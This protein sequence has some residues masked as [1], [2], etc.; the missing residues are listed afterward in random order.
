MCVC[1]F[2]CV[3]TRILFAV[4][5]R[6]LQTHR[7]CARGACIRSQYKSGPAVFPLLVPIS[8]DDAAAKQHR[9]AMN[10]FGTRPDIAVFMAIGM[11]DRGRVGPTGSL[12]TVVVHF[13]QWWFTLHSG[14]SLCT[15]VFHFAQWWFTLH[16]GGSLCTVVVHFAQCTQTIVAGWPCECVYS[17]I[18]CL[19]V[20]CVCLACAL[21]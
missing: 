11:R 10:W 9:R 18:F 12:C 6:M 5:V 19:M 16:S 20:I 8:P 15:V 17:Y 3:N 14:G 1:S 7:V 21:T 13:A 4:C 2:V